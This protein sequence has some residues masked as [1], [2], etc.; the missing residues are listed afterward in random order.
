MKRKISIISEK[1]EFYLCPE[2]HVKKDS[3]IM[4][5]VSRKVDL[6]PCGLPC[7]DGN[8]LYSIEEQDKI[9][10]LC[11]RLGRHEICDKKMAGDCV[12]FNIKRH[13]NPCISERK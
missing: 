4:I 2:C 12:D 13:N 9:Q 7:I 8:S 6:Y 3:K 1:E 11:V 10:E 5:R